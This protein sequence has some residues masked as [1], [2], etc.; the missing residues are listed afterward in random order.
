ME[1][2]WYLR[3]A[4]IGRLSV[5]ALAMSLAACTLPN[6]GSFTSNPVLREIRAK[7]LR[8][9]TLTSANTQKIPLIKQGRIATEFTRDDVRAAWGPPRSC[10][11]VF[12]TTRTVCSY[13]QSKRTLILG[14]VYKDYSY[15]SVYYVG[16][17]V[18]DW[19]TH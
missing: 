10:T 6:Y 11:R 1:N 18:I 17:H 7:H 19:Q 2:V 4:V 3:I 5:I 13:R 14:R 15:R 16:G 8:E 9:I 12:Q